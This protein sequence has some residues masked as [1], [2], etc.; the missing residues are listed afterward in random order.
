[1]LPETQGPSPFDAERLADI[2]KRLA[3]DSILPL[4]QGAIFTRVLLMQNPTSGRCYTNHE[5]A[6]LLG[7]SHPRLRTMVALCRPFVRRKDE[8]IER[9]RLR[10]LIRLS[11]PDRQGDRT[12]KQN[13]RKRR[14]SIEG[15]ENEEI[16][17][18][19]RMDPRTV[20]K[21]ESKIEEAIA[22]VIVKMGVRKLPLLPSQ[23][24]M[25]LMAKAAV[26]VFEAAVENK[27]RG[28]PAKEPVDE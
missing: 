18:V 15:A 21:L 22:E 23:Q 4:E 3:S 7:V 25:H 1:M 27:D 19:T 10:A 26:A 11:S 2:K 9:E 17:L 13:D 16:R 14:R 12:L 8:T 20:E 28:R 6:E 24:T 5:A